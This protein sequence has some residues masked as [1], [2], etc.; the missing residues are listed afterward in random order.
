VYDYSDNYWKKGIRMGNHFKFSPSAAYRWT[1]CP[2]SLAACEGLPDRTSSYAEEGTLAHAVGA[3]LLKGQHP[4]DCPEEMLDHCLEYQEL[5]ENLRDPD[6]VLEVEKEILSAIISGFGGTIDSLIYNPKPQELIVTDLKYGKGVPVFAENNLQLL[7][8]GSLACEAYMTKPVKT[9]KFYIFQPRA[10]TD[11]PLREDHSTPEALSSWRGG[12]LIPAIAKANEPNAPR[13]G[14]EWCR[15]CKAMATCPEAR[16]EVESRA[17]VALQ[18]AKTGMVRPPAPENLT[19]TEIANV[20]DFSAILADWITAVEANAMQRLMAGEQITGRKLVRKGTHRKWQDP[21]VAA[22]TLEKL[23]GKEV[24]TA[25]EL[26]SPAQAE[27]LAKGG[28]LKK[29]VASLAF[30]PE[31]EI[32]IAPITDKRPAINPAQITAETLAE[33]DSY[34]R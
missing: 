13:C 9:V 26:I 16:A 3:A 21:K 34:L 14:G 28:E 4:P 32:T 19:P 17:M 10:P 30:H 7:S 5:I 25:P 18:S 11:E 15:W 27:K 22:E 20:L 33:E 6:G 12:F 1:K 2:G 23:L 29:K 24:W 8:Y 31:G